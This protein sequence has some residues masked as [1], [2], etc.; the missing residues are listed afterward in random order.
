MLLVEYKSYG[1]H[2]GGDD[3]AFL[4]FSGAE[5]WQERVDGM[6]NADYVCLELQE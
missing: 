3:D 6:Y 1:T 4:H 2:S 5:Q